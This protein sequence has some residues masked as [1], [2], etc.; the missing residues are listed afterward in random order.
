MSRSTAVKITA[1][2]GTVVV[3]VAG[4]AFINARF[5][6]I[7]LPWTASAPQ[8]SAVQKTGKTNASVSNVPNIS[9]YQVIMAVTDKK[10]DGTVLSPVM[11]AKSVGE[12]DIMSDSVFGMTANIRHETVIMKKKEIDAAKKTPR[13]FSMKISETVSLN[14]PEMPQIIEGNVYYS[15]SNGIMPL[16][17][18]VMWVDPAV[19]DIAKWESAFKE[20]GFKAVSKEEVFNDGKNIKT[21]TVMDSNDPL[22]RGELLIVKDIAKKS[23]SV[24]YAA[25]YITSPADGEI[26]DFLDKTNASLMSEI[27]SAP[28][29]TGRFRWRQPLG[30]PEYRK[31]ATNGSFNVQTITLSDRFFPGTDVPVIQSTCELWNSV[32]IGYSWIMQKSAWEKIKTDVSDIFIKKSATDEELL[33]GVLSSEN[34]LLKVIKTAESGPGSDIVRIDVIDKRTDDKIAVMF[35]SF[36]MVNVNGLRGL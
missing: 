10:P 18:V 34:I 1:V 7:R 28:Y 26:R 3:L 13:K 35:D 4:A 23:E 36:G 6:H 11:F 29:S 9:S 27:V 19:K 17:L 8:S 30:I 22:V 33:S 16:D 32:P 12:Y 5:L 25:Y 15:H 2:I 31:N 21:V 24:G 14:T 20:S